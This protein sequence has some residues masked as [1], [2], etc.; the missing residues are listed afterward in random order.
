MVTTGDDHHGVTMARED[1]EEQ[2]HNFRLH[3]RA[4]PTHLSARS[5]AK[6]PRGL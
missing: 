1:S 4:Q 3:L 2:V 5:V 6:I